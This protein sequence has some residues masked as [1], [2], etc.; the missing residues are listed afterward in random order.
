MIGVGRR[1]P[2][3]TPAT[4]QPRG[5]PVGGWAQLSL[6]RLDP[7]GE[8]PYWVAWSV[9]PGVGPV[10]FARLLHRFGAAS[11]AWAAGTEAL[12]ELPRVAS[13]AQDAFSAL[14]RRGATMVAAEVVKRTEAAGGR[15]VT[16]L[17]AGYPASLAAVDPR[18]AVLHVTGDLAVLERRTVAV[19]GTRRASGYGLATAA[20]LAD[21][22]ARAGIVVV[23]GLAVG[24]DGAAHRSA[25]DAGGQSVAVLPTPLGAI[26][27]PRHRELATRLVATGGALVSELAIGHPIGR[28]DFA[29]RNRLIAALAEAVVVV[30]APNRSGALLTAQAA[31]ELERTLFAVPGQIDASVAVGCNRLIADSQATIVT[32]AAGLLAQLRAP[33]GATLPPLVTGLSDAE[34]MVLQ[35]V[36]TRSGSIEELL[37]RTGLGTG[38]VAAALTMLEARGLVTAFGGATFHP[39]LA[40]RRLDGR[41]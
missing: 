19:V 36:L 35:R 11:A 15:V 5:E 38:T 3:R 24:I 39:T 2:R 22:L 26:Y 31:V 29:R 8:R 23:S 40:A 21:E 13:G 1:G 28:P 10:G 34:A 32:S 9:V 16:A 17:D 4:G 25:V 12:D 41:V 6:D 37:D 7:E 20:E 14:R 27:P 30:E 33:R 18:P